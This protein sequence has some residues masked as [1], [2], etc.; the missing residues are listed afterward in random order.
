MQYSLRLVEQ[1]MKPVNTYL[2]FII[3]HAQHARSFRINGR[4]NNM[5]KTVIH[6]MQTGDALNTWKVLKVCTLWYELEMHLKGIWQLCITLIVF[7][8][9]KLSSIK[10]KNLQAFFLSFFFFRIGNTYSYKT[11]NIIYKCMHVRKF[12]I[13]ENK[14][15]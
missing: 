6:F 10:C 11:I 8:K 12:H 13:L 14:I 15:I 7:I 5:L 3:V 1:F 9:K 4:K 2:C